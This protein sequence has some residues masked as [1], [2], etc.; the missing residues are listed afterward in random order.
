MKFFRG[1]SLLTALPRRAS[2]REGEAN[3][4]GDDRCYAPVISLIGSN[5]PSLG[6]FILLSR[7]ICNKNGD[8][9][10]FLSAMDRLP[11]AYRVSIPPFQPAEN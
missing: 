6:V 4:H 1:I 2:I 7:S 5:P 10:R 8:L 9:S 11:L 3:L